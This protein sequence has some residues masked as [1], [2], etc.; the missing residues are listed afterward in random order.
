MNIINEIQRHRVIP[1]IEI[2]SVANVEPLVEA[3][4]AGGI[5]ILEITLRTSSAI[6]AISIICKQFPDML[7]GAG[8]V[9]T[10]EQSQ[11]VQDAGA[12]FGFAPGLNPEV[13]KS[14]HDNALTFIPG[15][16]TPTEIEHAVKLDCH[17]LKFFPAS[18][19]GGPSFLKALSGP[20]AWSGIQF[21]ATGG[22]NLKNM[23][24]Y[25]EIPTVAAI[26]GSWIAAR[27]QIAE[28]SWS[29]ITRQARQAIQSITD[30]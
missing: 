14:F 7:V 27:R 18:S 11:K 12:Q 23:N 9:L 26:G 25:L 1:V 6:D 30:D 8:T 5:N 2:D 3:L 15:V 19:A 21:C 29:T 24:Q 4:L 28:R 22:V 16:M 10:L 13:V 20:Y 17:Y